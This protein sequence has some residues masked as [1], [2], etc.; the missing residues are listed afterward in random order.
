MGSSRVRQ[1]TLTFS[2]KPSRKESKFLDLEVDGGQC[3]NEC[4]STSSHSIKDALQPVG[5]VVFVL[6]QGDS[7]IAQGSGHLVKVTELQG[8]AV[9]SAARCTVNT[10]FAIAICNSNL[11]YHREFL[12]GEAP[13]HIM[14]I[15]AAVCLISIITSAK[16]WIPHNT[17]NF[18]QSSNQ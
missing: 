17:A 5:F 3:D 4:I 14:Q 16:L 18:P 2:Q 11:Q 8:T 7:Y 13:E 12:Y 9:R 6:V 15:Q 10:I 1:R